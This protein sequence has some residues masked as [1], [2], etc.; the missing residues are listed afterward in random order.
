M[1]NRAIQEAAVAHGAQKRKGTDIPYTTHPFMVAMILSEAGYTEDQVVAGVLHDTLE[2][3]GLTA[4]YIENLFG[5][6]VAGIVVGCTEPD[7][8]LPWEDR[9]QHTINYLKTAPSEIRAVSCADKLH[10]VRWMTT[11]YEA[12]GDDLWNR[13][14]AGKDGQEWYYKGLVGSLCDRLEQHPDNSIFHQFKMAVSQLFDSSN[15]SS[16]LDI[17]YRT[18]RAS[19]CA[20]P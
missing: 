13:F 11:D 3:T 14:N 16:A 20:T 15:G 18:K 8:S 4:D 6:N 1:L 10:N 9:K 5:K 7:R 12:I 19:R 17:H 2:D